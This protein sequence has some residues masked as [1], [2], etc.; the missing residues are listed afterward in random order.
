[1]INVIQTEIPGVVIIEPKVFG[2]ER[3]YFFESWSQKDFDEQVRPIKFVQDNES[4]SS[5][6]VLRGL[7]FQ[8]GKHAQSKLVRVVK[9]KV[10]DVAVDIRKGSPTFG[11]HVAVELTEDNHR[12]FFVPRG[13]AHGFVVLSETAVFQYKCDNLYAPTE[14]GALAW[15][16]PEIG[17]DWGVPADKVILSAKDKVHPMLKEST[18]LFDY[19]LDYYAE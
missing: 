13:F 2:D 11:K 19:N 4:K 1:M 12:Q 10:L 5:Y 16:D 18:E 6:G 14:E 15:D 17:I 8:K 9:G 7:H 3:G